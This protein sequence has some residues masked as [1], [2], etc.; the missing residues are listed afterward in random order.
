MKKNPN[1]TQMISDVIQ[2]G[3]S[4]WITQIYK[5]N[6]HINKGKHCIVLLF[7]IGSF[8]KDSI[9]DANYNEIRIKY[10]VTE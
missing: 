6:V 1:L 3:D 5:I 8:K 10:N 4:L 7:K 9:K 2:F